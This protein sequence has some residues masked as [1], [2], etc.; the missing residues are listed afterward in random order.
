MAE[1]AIIENIQREN[2]NPVEEAVAINEL[3]ESHNITQEQ[4]AKRLGKSRTYVTNL[5][6]ILKTDSKVMDAVLESKISHGHAKAIAAL[7]NK[8]QRMM[9]K[10]IL[11]SNLNVRDVESLVK[12]TKPTTKKNTKSEDYTYV[13]DLVRNKLKTKVEITNNKI[14]IKYKGND[15]LNRILERIGALED[16]N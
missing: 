2:L 7:P 8:E 4:A 14:T 6:R 10:K 11:E 15:Q 13:E 12:K 3:I 9:L 5:L 16:G 1:I